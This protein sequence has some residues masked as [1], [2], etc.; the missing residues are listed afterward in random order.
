[1]DCLE[2]RKLDLEAQQFDRYKLL[3]ECEQDLI[4]EDDRIKKGK[5]T[6][7]ISQ[8]KQEIKTCDE[9]LKSIEQQILISPTKSKP[10]PI[11]QNPKHQPK[12][13]KQSSNSYTELIEQPQVKKPRKVR[14]T[15]LLICT[16]IFV[17][18][19]VV[20]A[21]RAFQNECQGT[22][23]VEANSPDGREFK[24]PNK[25]R[26]IQFN[27]SGRWTYLPEV[28]HSANGHPKQRYATDNYL[29]PRYPEGSLIVLRGN[30]VYEYV[31]I[32]KRLSLES[33]E[34]VVFT[35]NEGTNPD[36]FK[37]NNGKLNIEWHCV[38]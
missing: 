34:T 12:R 36:Y 30:G 20:A 16:I 10:L 14:F 35:I 26:V 18:I 17:T 21:V 3:N 27:A 29:L 4:V 23:C 9:D 37:D 24:N 33:N 13:E 25:C 1:M 7:Q 11:A 6:R 38:E 15:W 19:T 5:L 22:F 28:G 8:L 32:E 31:G 2:Q